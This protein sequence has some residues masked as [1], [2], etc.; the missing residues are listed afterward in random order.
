LR[1]LDHNVYVHFSFPPKVTH[2]GNILLNW[3][4]RKE[5]VLGSGGIAP[6]TLNFGTRWWK[7]TSRPGCF[8]PMVRS[9]VPIWQE[10]EWAPEPVWTRR[11]REKLP[12]LPLPGIEPRSS[13]P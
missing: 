13:S 8:T 2:H 10:D 3:P 6:R 4:P 12:S 9:P 7:V 1:F 11:R 5:D